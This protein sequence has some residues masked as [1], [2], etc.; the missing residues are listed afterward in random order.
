MKDIPG[1]EGGEEV[2]SDCEDC[3]DCERLMCWSHVHRAITPQL[4][5]LR[6][7]NKEVASDLLSDI[8]E[9]QW[10]ANNSTFSSLVNLLE[11][12]YSS[13]VSLSAEIRHALKNFQKT[14]FQIPRTD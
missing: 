9:I 8:E 3:R 6:L 12:K 2:F 1:N 14:F 11:K 10:L 13:N 4:K 5:S 7:L